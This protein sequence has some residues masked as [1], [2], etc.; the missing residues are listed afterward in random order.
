MLDKDLCRICNIN[1]RRN[2]LS[3]DRLKSRFEAMWTRHGEVFCHGMGG[4]T[5]NIPITRAEPPCECLM[6]LEYLMKEELYK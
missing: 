1:N 2:R 5:G 4:Q 3:E 6:A